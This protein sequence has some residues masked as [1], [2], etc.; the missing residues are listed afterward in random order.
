MKIKILLFLI[1]WKFSSAV[2]CESFTLKIINLP[3]PP[4]QRNV[5]KLFNIGKNVYGIIPE[6]SYHHGRIITF[7]DNGVRQVN[8]LPS[9]VLV[10][11]SVIFNPE[12]TWTWDKSYKKIVVLD[13]QGVL[14]IYDNNG[15]GKEIQT[16]AGTRPFEKSSYQ[17]SR[18]FAMG[19]DNCIYTAGKDGYIFKLNPETMEVKKLN[20]RLPSVKGREAWASLD[21]ATV[22]DDGTIYFGTFDG[23]I[24]SFNP[25][26]NVMKNL[27]K[28]FRQ[29]RI[30][31]LVYFNNIIF[32]IGGEPDG[33]PRWF[34][35][36]TIAGT[37]EIGGTLKNTENKLIY[38]PVNS[39]IYLENNKIYGSFSGRL[40]SLFV[41]QYER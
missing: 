35:Y 7:D 25:E 10:V 41:I 29:Q 30:Q 21:A 24:A 31:A 3:F 17:V 20:V 27:G 26:S 16:I 13:P 5:T 11:E 1:L 12:L 8:N 2:L 15:P 18:T 33:L 40:G 37:F 28:P 9:D 14:S 22:T 36:D 32:G 6:C 34:I 4:Y 39:M 19:R 38:E 23:Y